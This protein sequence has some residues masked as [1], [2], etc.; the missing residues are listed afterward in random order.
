MSKLRTLEDKMREP[1]SMPWSER[2]RIELRVKRVLER[3]RS[4]ELAVL[5][6]GFLHSEVFRDIDIAV[7]T[8][9]RVSY[10]E[11]HAYADS[12]RDKLERVAG[13][14][15]DVQILDYAP[16]DFT[17]KVLSE[18]KILL[19]KTP[20]IAAILRIHALEDLRRL[21]RDPL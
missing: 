11:S 18:G 8:G 19:E 3:E 6:G 21:R 4:V 13:I 17:Y 10:S 2:Y 9:H 5:H 1:K 14:A 16:P 7:Y 15:V 20:G 12:L